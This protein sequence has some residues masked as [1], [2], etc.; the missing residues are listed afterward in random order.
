MRLSQADTRTLA[1]LHAGAH[2]VEA[3]VA[4][5]AGS[6]RVTDPGPVIDPAVE[7]SDVSWTWDENGFGGFLTLP[8]LSNRVTPWGQRLRIRIR[9]TRDDGLAVT[10]PLP[11]AVITR[12]VAARPDNTLEVTFEGLETLLKQTELLAARPLKT[13]KD[14]TVKHWLGVLLGEAS[15]GLGFTDPGK[16]VSADTLPKGAAWEP[17]VNIWQ[18]VQDMAVDAGGRLQFDTS[19][20]LHVVPLLPGGDSSPPGTGT[21]KHPAATIATGSNLI[22]ATV[23][24]SREG[25]ANRVRVSLKDSD[26]PTKKNPVTKPGSLPVVPPA[27]PIA[28]R[29]EPGDRIAYPTLNPSPPV[30]LRQQGG[31]QNGRPL[32]GYRENTGMYYSGFPYRFH[33]AWDIPTPEG[34]AIYAPLNGRIAKV[35]AHRPEGTNRTSDLNYILMHT[36]AADEVYYNYTSPKVPAKMRPLVRTGEKITIAFLHLKRNGAE[37]KEG[38][39]VTA[40]DLIGRVGLSGRTSGY[41]LHIAVQTGWNTGY[42][43]APSWE[44]SGGKSVNIFPPGGVW[45]QRNH[46]E[47]VGEG[48]NR[49]YAYERAGGAELLAPVDSLAAVAGDSSQAGT[50]TT[51]TGRERWDGPMGRAS[52][53]VSEERVNPAAGAAAAL[54]KHLL[55]VRSSQT[56]QTDAETLCL[57][58]LCPGDVVHVDGT[59]ATVGTVSCAL[60]FQ[61]MQV[62]LREVKA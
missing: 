14:R 42:M 25:Y 20:T 53:Y 61:S 10:V 36:Y 9:I 34:T 24:R 11:W 56:V 1:E 4:L 26:I 37:V 48:D 28:P 2:R 27:T 13:E 41:H 15:P 50:A 7:V 58:H 22:A 39:V 33:G 52:V 47:A 31:P 49:G 59:P 46:A 54:A 57:P 40:G 38:Q 62:R 45:K 18:A 32:D 5:H 8:L 6:S 35:I 21:V 43:Q 23:T 16:L 51:V 19:G 3:L 44:P 17:G 55:A 30:K 12:T 29:P 60:P